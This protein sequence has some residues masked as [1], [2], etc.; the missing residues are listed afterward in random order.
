[1]G[2]VTDSSGAVVANIKV[3]LTT[4]ARRSRGRPRPILSG[5]RLYLPGRNL[6][7]Q[8]SGYGFEAVIVTDCSVS[9]TSRRQDF[10]MK[11]GRVTEMVQISATQ[12]AVNSENPTLVAK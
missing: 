5:Y 11:V 7:A 8:G 3:T 9:A 6:F 10:T 2:T 12:W 4:W 1:L